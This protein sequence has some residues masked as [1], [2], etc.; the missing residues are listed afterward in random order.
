MC[1]R[2]CCDNGWEASRIHCINEKETIWTRCIFCRQHLVARNLS[3]E[4]HNSL[5]IVIKCINKIKVHSLNDRLF[6]ALCHDN[7]EDFECLLLHTAV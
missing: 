3:A 4:L 2:R 6:C 5:H 7:E 1:N